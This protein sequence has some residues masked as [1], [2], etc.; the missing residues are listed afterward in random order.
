MEYEPPQVL[1]SHL[2]VGTDP[3]KYSKGLQTKLMLEL[4]PMEDETELVVWT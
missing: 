1:E 4:S 3:K 2:S